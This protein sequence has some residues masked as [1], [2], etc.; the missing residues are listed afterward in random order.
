ME[1][2]NNGLD[3]L[4]FICCFCVI[5]FHCEIPLNGPLTIL[6]RCAVPC[7]FI[8][9]GYYILN[10]FDRHRITYL[11]KKL[12]RLLSLS[13]IIFLFYRLLVSTIGVG[14]F[15]KIKHPV[16][17]FLLFNEN[18]F[19]Y[20]LWYISACIYGLVILY[21]L[22][23]KINIYSLQ[24]TIF[25]LVV[26]LVGTTIGLMEHVANDSLWNF[27]ICMVRNFLFTA[28]PYLVLG[29][30]IR[31]HNITK[32]KQNRIFCLL[33]GV[34]LFSIVEYN[35]IAGIGYKY[36]CDSFFLTWVLSAIVF[37]WFSSLRIG[38]SVFSKI[39]KD[40][41]LFIYIFHPII[42]MIV[43]YGSRSIGSNIDKS[44]LFPIAVMFFS[45]FTYY[46][47]CFVKKRILTILKTNN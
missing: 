45:V 9:T 41:S 43:T 2:R 10:N 36:V 29:G 24:F 46:I 3:L 16:F 14:E 38:G 31:K 32:I 19:G 44:W 47:L 34:Y 6:F 12:T 11:V 25:T 22:S 13:T 23:K 15:L 7:F 39:G 20:H 35:Y 26:T 42:K 8:I 4:K 33:L 37:L 30:F 5:V 27:R 18:P 21:V 1:L 17:D 40:C 28:I